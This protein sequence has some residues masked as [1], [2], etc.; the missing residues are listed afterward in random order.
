MEPG[1]KT[2]SS[3]AIRH[4]ACQQQL[5]GGVACKIYSCNT[6]SGVNGAI[7]SL[8]HYSR[9]CIYFYYSQMISICHRR[10][11]VLQQINSDHYFCN[12]YNTTT[13]YP[14]TINGTFY[15]SFLC[16][17]S[18]S[19][20]WLTNPLLFVCCPMYHSQSGSRSPKFFHDPPIS[21]CYLPTYEILYT[22]MS[23]PM[24]LPSKQYSWLVY[25]SCC[26]IIL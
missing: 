1:S 8:Y 10:W 7:S 17:L 18:A 3:Y 9:V 12:N 16:P 20:S 6:P 5:G 13:K 26:S 4:I 19:G 15:A 22:P 11:M 25:H 24:S 2:S 21:D 14:K 23:N